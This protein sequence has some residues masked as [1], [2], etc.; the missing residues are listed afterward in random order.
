MKE[1]R[2]YGRGSV[3]NLTEMGE[4]GSDVACLQSYRSDLGDA[5]VEIP[6]AEDGVRVCKYGLLALLEREGT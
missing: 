5:G 2:L 6:V 1:V 3:H 4:K